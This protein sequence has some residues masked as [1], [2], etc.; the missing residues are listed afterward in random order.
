M[1][2]KLFCY[3]ANEIFCSFSRCGTSSVLFVWFFSSLH[4]SEQNTSRCGWEIKLT[5]LGKG[6]SH[7]L[8][9]VL[10]RSLCSRRN[11]SARCT[12]SKKP[13]QGFCALYHLS[14]HA[15]TSLLVFHPM[16]WPYF[17]QLQR[18]KKSPKFS[19]IELT[20]FPTLCSLLIH[21]ERR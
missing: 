14:T 10:R 20:F 15:W 1:L 9:R 21:P 17:A 16:N 7:A 18:A 19:M 3:F 8:L 13:E 2:W 5:A 12:W 4:P 11:T 6:T